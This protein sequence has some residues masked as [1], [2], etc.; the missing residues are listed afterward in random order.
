MTTWYALVALML[1]MFTVDYL[2][3]RRKTRVNMMTVFIVV[4]LSILSGIRGENY[5]DFKAYRLYFELI[6]PLTAILLENESLLGGLHYRLEPLYQLV[7]SI[8]KVFSSSFNLYL[9]FQC[10]FLLLVVVA[11]LKRFKA[12]VNIGLIVYFFL[13]YLQQFGQQRMSIIFVLC[14]FA[15]SFL[16]TN[17]LKKFVLTVLVATG[18]HYTALFYLPAYGFSWLLLSKLPKRSLSSPPDSA[19]PEETG[20]GSGPG[21]RRGFRKHAFRSITLSTV[22]KIAALVAVAFAVTIKFNVFERLNDML[23]ASS[24]LLGENVYS[25]K[26]TKNY[27]LITDTPNIMD[28]WFGLS[29]LIVIGIFLYVFRKHWMADHTA[30]LFVNYW[31]GIIILV[32][33][34]KFPVLTDRLF[35]MYGYTALI[36]LFAFMSRERRKNSVVTLPFIL[37]VCLYLFLHKIDTETRG[38]HTM[39][40]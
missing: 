24:D 36:V 11:A 22:V 30:P 20:G 26:F 21:A 18:F 4:L 3:N 27:K 7:I 25:L 1:V 14:L 40:F 9:F 17:D 10:L 37:V 38:Y 6:P 5:P 15:S 29:S 8:F 32:L 13:L 2:E 39:E 31:M 34:Y 33:V 12:P 28:A 35:R 23:F 16:V 19:A